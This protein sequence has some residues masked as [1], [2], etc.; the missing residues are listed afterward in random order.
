MAASDPYQRPDTRSPA[1][2]SHISATELK[3][4][5]RE[6]I[7]RAARHATPLS[8]LLVTIEQLSRSSPEGGDVLLEQV[9][10]YI[11]AALAPGLRSFDRIGRPSESEL[12]IVLPGA[13]GPRGEAV[14]RRVLA[15]LKTIKLE[16]DGVR[17]PL[18]VSVGLAV[19]SDDA[20]DE[21]MLAQGRAA[22]AG[23]PGG[24][25]RPRAG[26]GA[27]GDAVRSEP[28]AAPTAGAPPRGRHGTA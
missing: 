11:A 8:C 27:D 28:G 19:W 15:R 25:A 22:A 6:E 23:R 14:G 3:R 24:G 12:M 2:V 5:L 20:D 13:D 21:D 9:L 17:R 1:R 4:R 18:R 16:T 10:A 7:N 26:G